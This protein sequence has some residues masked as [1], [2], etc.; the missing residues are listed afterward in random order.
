MHAS[1]R[2]VTKP[3]FSATYPTLHPHPS[4][5]E[6]SHWPRRTCIQ[7]LWAT[8]EPSCLA[9]GYRI[10]I[11]VEGRERRSFNNGGG[12]GEDKSGT[13]KDKVLCDLR[14][15]WWSWRRRWWWSW[16]WI[17]AD[18][19]PNWRINKCVESYTFW[20]LRMTTRSISDN[21]SCLIEACSGVFCSLRGFG[22]ICPTKTT[23]AFGMLGI[24]AGRS[25]I[26]I[27]GSA[28]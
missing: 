25:C 22:I 7:T 19:R 18:W 2:I 15:W 6:V 5:D 1:H 4:I 9:A 11:E 23:T 20:Y 26:T 17:L 12:K 27:D 10:L 28:S 16:R 8:D 3:L 14:G 13:N 21:G 24:K